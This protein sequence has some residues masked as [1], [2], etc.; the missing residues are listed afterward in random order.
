MAASSKFTGGSL[1]IAL[2]AAYSVL[3]IRNVRKE[4]FSIGET[5]FI[6]GVVTFLGFAVGTPK[7]LTWMAYYFKRVLAALDWQ[8]TWGRR[9]D[10]LRGIIG[11]YP[12][13]RESLGT[14]L[15]II[16]LVA[17]G[18]T[19]YRLIRAYRKGELNR[20]SQAGAFGI[21]LLGILALDLPIMVSYNYQPR[22]L[23]TF[24]PLLAILAAFFIEDVF[25]WVKQFGRSAYTTIFM[26][27]LAGIILYSLARLASVTLLFVNDARI[28]ASDFMSTLPRGTSLEHTNYPPNYTGGY[29]K[30]EHNYPLYI[31]MGTIDTVPTDKPYEFNQA[32]AGL[33][34]RQTDYLIVDSFSAS[35]F[36]D[37]YVC[38]QIPL[39][40][41]FFKQ[42]KT[43]RSD[44]YQLIA[45]F[46]YSLPW[47]L[48][49]VVVTFAN[50]EIRIYE[51]IK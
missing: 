43:G 28:P 16:F 35:R 29:F 32:E 22:Y 18:W 4:W 46:N 10:S 5:L 2:L 26:T 9:D 23:L 1:L 37:P 17:I 31:Q 27:G 40:C 20:T 44:H 49:Q 25:L 47:Y 15:Y 45:E 39:E 19:C 34:D 51:R 36:D 50:P 3:Q 21:L 38:E 30:R 41:D 6:S 33:L 12:L 14:A 13:M 42:L 8:V 24:M 7:S 11:Q 48:P